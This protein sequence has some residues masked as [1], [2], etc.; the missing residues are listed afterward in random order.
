VLLAHKMAMESDKIRAEAIEAAEFPEM[1]MQYNVRAVP[2][3]IINDQDVLEGA[4]PE[5]IFVG[6]ILQ[7]VAK[8]KD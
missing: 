5:S 6:R 1:A 4:V 8:P 3:T 2:R 7:S